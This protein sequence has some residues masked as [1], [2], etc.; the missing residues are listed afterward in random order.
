VGRTCRTKNN[1]AKPTNSQLTITVILSSYP[2]GP[3]AKVLELNPCRFCFGSIE[4]TSETSV[5][6]CLKVH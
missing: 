2:V 1:K 4:V 5:G 3:R 6:E